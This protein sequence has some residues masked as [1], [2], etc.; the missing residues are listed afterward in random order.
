MAKWKSCAYT[1]KSSEYS[2]WPGSRTPRFWVT[3]KHQL[4]RKLNVHHLFPRKVP[5]PSGHRLIIPQTPLQFSTWSCPICCSWVKQH[6]EKFYSIG[7]RSPDKTLPGSIH[8]SELHTLW[9]EHFLLA[10][11]S[12]SLCCTVAHQR[13]SGEMIG[14]WPGG[15]LLGNST[16]TPPWCKELRTVTCSLVICSKH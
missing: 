12:P 4:G 16:L 7:S 13:R 6:G 15:I 1:W 14:Q 9:T 11:L 8:L 3:L 2:T 5:W 10:C